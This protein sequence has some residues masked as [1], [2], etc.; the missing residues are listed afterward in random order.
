M[1]SVAYPEVHA[2]VALILDEAQQ[3]VLRSWNPRRV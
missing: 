1:A 3:K 2:A